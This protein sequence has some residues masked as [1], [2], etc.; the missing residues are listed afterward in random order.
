MSDM[1]D[2]ETITAQL[3][4]ALEQLRPVRFNDISAIGYGHVLAA[5]CLISEALGRLDSVRKQQAA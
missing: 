4:A 1:R 5:R 3:E 2:L